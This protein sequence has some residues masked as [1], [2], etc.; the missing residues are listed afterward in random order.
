MHSDP[1]L[2]KG[3]V[4]IRAVLDEEGVKAGNMVNLAGIVKDCRLPI[5]TK[6]SGRPP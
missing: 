5:P 1:A 2:P 6:G 3:F 4:C